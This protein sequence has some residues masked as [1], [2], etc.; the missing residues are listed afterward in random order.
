[1]LKTISDGER[2]RSLTRPLG[3]SVRQMPPSRQERRKEERD[4]A[5]NAPARAGAGGAAAALAKN[6]NPIGD[7]TTQAADPCV[8]PGGYCL[9]R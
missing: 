3:C 7:W 2:T 6:V 8:G 9:A 5:K 4:A 1:V